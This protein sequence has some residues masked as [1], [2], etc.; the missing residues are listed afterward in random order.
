MWRK[1]KVLAFSGFTEG[2]GIW[3]EFCGNNKKEKNYANPRMIS[4]AVSR[5]TAF[6]RDIWRARLKYTLYDWTHVSVANGYRLTVAFLFLTTPKYS[7]FT[8]TA[9]CKCDVR[10]EVIVKLSQASCSVSWELLPIHS[11]SRSFLR[12]FLTVFE[13]SLQTFYG[14]YQVLSEF[15]GVFY[16]SLR[17]C[18]QLCTKRLHF[19][20]NPYDLREML[21]ICTIRFYR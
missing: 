4:L 7:N 11:L 9:L 12:I 8:I 10:K 13:E 6:F 17:K 2:S 3:D 1:K 15:F 18:C 5:G 16:S 14:I 19:S 21:M 20:G